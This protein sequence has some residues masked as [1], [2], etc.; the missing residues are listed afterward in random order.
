MRAIKIPQRHEV[1]PEWLRHRVVPLLGET[2]PLDPDSAEY[3]IRVTPQAKEVAN[4]ISGATVRLTN[5][6][7]IVEAPDYDP[8]QDLEKIKLAWRQTVGPPVE[9]LDANSSRARAVM[10]NVDAPTN[11]VFV[12]EASNSSG[13]RRVE[14]TVTVHPSRTRTPNEMK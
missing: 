4:A 1:Y 6:L 14:L 8:F 7:S 2:L 11:L 13:A 3:L 10:P 5:Q 9:I 12:L